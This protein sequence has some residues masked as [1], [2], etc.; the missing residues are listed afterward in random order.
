MEGPL[1]KGGGLHGL[2]DAPSSG[3]SQATSPTIGAKSARNDSNGLTC[4]IPDPRTAR[5]DTFK[6]GHACTLS[7]PRQLSSLTWDDTQE[8][9][10]YDASAAFLPLRWMLRKEK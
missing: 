10:I 3:D 4:Y 9:L 5:Q 2:M 6:V 8:G 1:L 7:N